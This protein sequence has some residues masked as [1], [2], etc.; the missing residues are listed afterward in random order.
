[1][2]NGDG[3]GGRTSRVW[4]WESS[5]RKIRKKGGRVSSSHSQA[6]LF[7]VTMHGMVSCLQHTGPH[8]M[9]PKARKERGPTVSRQV[10]R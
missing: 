4:M 1:M 5:E 2:S 7:A 9:Q 8:S 10:D 3:N 6:T